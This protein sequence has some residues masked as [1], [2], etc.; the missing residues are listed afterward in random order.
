MQWIQSW[1]TPLHMTGIREPQGLKTECGG[2]CYTFLIGNRQSFGK[3]RAARRLIFSGFD[4]RSRCQ[5]SEKGEL[6]LTRSQSNEWSE[7]WPC[8]EGLLWVRLWSQNK[9]VCVGKELVSS[10]GRIRWLG[11]E[12]LKSWLQWDGC[13][14]PSSQDKVGLH[15]KRW[16]FPH[17]N[18]QSHRRGTS[19]A[20]RLPHVLTLKGHHLLFS[21]YGGLTHQ[22]LFRTSLLH[23]GSRKPGACPHSIVL[24]AGRDQ[25][26]HVRASLNVCPKCTKIGCNKE[27]RVQ[28]GQVTIATTGLC[29]RHILRHMHTHSHTHTFA[30][31]L[32][33]LK[34]TFEIVFLLKTPAFPIVKIVTCHWN[35]QVCKINLGRKW[36][37]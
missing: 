22:V 25:W 27:V 20:W 35:P 1:S 8:W 13:N 5:G 12:L 4:L 26:P 14:L 3:T 2:S 10:K 23:Y 36:F 31:F 37:C 28:G 32:N 15:G 16:I 21:P 7:N 17:Y 11:N 29:L 6:T 19:G 9:P 34:F 24:C 30:W 18:W 33:I